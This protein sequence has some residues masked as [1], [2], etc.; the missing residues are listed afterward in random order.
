M[1]PFIQRLIQPHELNPSKQVILSSVLE[2]VALAA[3]R[4]M[5]QA[6]FSYIKHQVW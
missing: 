2:A 1:R 5:N 4:V 6:E 3:S